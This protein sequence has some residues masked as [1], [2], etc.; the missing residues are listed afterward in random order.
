LYSITGDDD[1]ALELLEQ[2]TRKRGL[3]WYP[4]VSDD[5]CFRKAFDGA[6]RYQ[7]ILDSIVERK[8]RLR[9]RLPETLARFGLTD[10]AYTPP[11]TVKTPG[12]P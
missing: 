1:R 9:E 2:M 8:R 3:P 12:S 10:V 5:P 6:P 7:A 4:R 11:T